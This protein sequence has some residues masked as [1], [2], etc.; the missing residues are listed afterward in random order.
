MA[1]R[2]VWRLFLTV[3]AFSLFSHNLLRRVPKAPG[4][5]GDPVHVKGVGDTTVL[6]QGFCSQK[7]APVSLI[8][9]AKCLLPSLETY[10]RDIQRCL[11]CCKNQRKGCFLKSPFFHERQLCVFSLIDHTRVFNDR[12]N[13]E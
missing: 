6:K 3:N 11:P 2:N 12:S 9:P 13:C 4:H 1:R 7:I 5:S 10:Y 8:V